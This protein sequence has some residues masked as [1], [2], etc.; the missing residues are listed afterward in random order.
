MCLAV[1]CVEGGF[2]KSGCSYSTTNNKVFAFIALCNFV[3][4]PLRHL[5]IAIQNITN[6]LCNTF[7][8]I[9]Y[10][11]QHYVM[12][13]AHSYKIPLLTCRVPRFDIVDITIL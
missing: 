5:T 13:L 10:V 9:K 8:H 2:L 7:N 3:M 11:W 1:V 12:Y 4:F 6:V